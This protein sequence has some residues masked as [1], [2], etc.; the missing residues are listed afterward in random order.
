[1]QSSSLVSSLSRC[2]F[3]DLAKGTHAALVRWYGPVLAQGISSSIAPPP[4]VEREK[5]RKLPEK[6]RKGNKKSKPRASLS[7]E[8]TS[9][10]CSLSLQDLDNIEEPVALD[11]A[12][13]PSWTPKSPTCQRE[14]SPSLPY[15]IPVP[16]SLRPLPPRMITVALRPPPGAFS[17]LLPP[18]P[19]SSLSLPPASQQPSSTASNALPRIYPAPPP[20]VD[21]DP[22][23]ENPLDGHA[24]KTS[25]ELL[26]DALWSWFNAGYQTALYH[27]AMAGL[28]S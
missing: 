21:L 4:P 24:T 13:S 26:Q 12:G 17:T 19:I 1:M 8:L 23:E 3:I 18:P 11:R 16:L 10:T 25:E 2:I 5:K 7:P 22:N 14:R 9:W 15:S 27:A 28:K 20:I 6:S